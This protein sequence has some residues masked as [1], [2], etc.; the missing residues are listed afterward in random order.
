[1]RRLAIALC[2]ITGVARAD[3][4]PRTLLLRCQGKVTHLI[5]G[6]DSLDDKVDKTLRLKDGTIG[7]IR[8]NFLEGEGCRLDS[9]VIKCALEAVFPDSVLNVTEK[10]HTLLTLDRETGEYHYM[11]ETWGYEGKGIAEDPTSHRRS[12]FSGICDTIGGRIF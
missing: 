12:M 7:D 4:I 10:R 5:S 6:V 9:G 1:M 8:C 3:D 11:L 2:L